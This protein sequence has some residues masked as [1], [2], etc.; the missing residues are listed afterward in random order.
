MHFFCKLS[1]KSQVGPALLGSSFLPVLPLHCWRAQLGHNQKDPS[2]EG[3][4]ME[5]T[6]SLCQVETRLMYFPGPM[7]LCPVLCITLGLPAGICRQLHVVLFCTVSRGF[8]GC[9]ILAH[10][11]HKIFFL[12]TN[13]AGLEP[14]K[15]RFHLW[16]G[17]SAG[18][19]ASWKYS[20]QS[21]RLAPR[22]SLVLSLL[23]C[24]CSL[25]S[26]RMWSSSWMLL[27]TRAMGR[28]CFPS[29]R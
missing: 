22:K 28:A 18:M 4:Q 1:I 3:I 29:A 16:L 7:A 24:D 14:G 12:D 21:D 8:L 9:F 11:G 13:T 15:M 2:R 19:G 25:D 27:N 6:L 10:I 20:A 17:I 26:A 23:A 5:T